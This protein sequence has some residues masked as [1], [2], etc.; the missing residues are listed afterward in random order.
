MIVINRDAS[1][2]MAV[3]LLDAGGTPRYYFIH[4]IE[5]GQLVIE[6]VRDICEEAWR[7]DNIS[8]MKKTAKAAE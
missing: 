5:I 8:K 4:D 1:D 6:M 2:T 3:R 7:F